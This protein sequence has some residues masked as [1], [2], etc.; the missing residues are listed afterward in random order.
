MSKYYN[1]SIWDNDFLKFLN[2]DIKPY[3]IYEIKNRFTNSDFNNDYLKFKM[4][5]IK[6][7]IDFR[8]VI[9]HNITYVIKHF[10]IS[11]DDSNFFKINS[12]DYGNNIEDITI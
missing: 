4:L 10:I 3:Y 9:N 5:L 1:K 8:L 11:E 6:K 12:Y 7:G 2:L